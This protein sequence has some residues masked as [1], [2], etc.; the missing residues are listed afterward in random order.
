MKYMQ[1]QNYKND[2]LEK[3]NKNKKTIIEK[4]HQF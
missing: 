3:I 2:I 4:I 1:Y